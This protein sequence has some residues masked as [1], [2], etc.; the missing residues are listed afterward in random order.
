MTVIHRNLKTAG[1]LR[2]MIAE[3]NRKDLELKRITKTASLL[4]LSGLSANSIPREIAR[5]CAAEQRQ[6]GGWVGVVDSGWNAFFLK[7]LDSE[8]YGESIGKALDFIRSQVNEQGL[9]GRS[10]R[11]ISRIPVS[12]ILMYLFPGLAEPQPLL[13]LEQL[14]ISEKNSITYKAAYT[15]MAFKRARYRPQ[16]GTLIEETVDW[17]AA[18]QLQDGGFSPWKGHPLDADVFCTA[19]AALGLRQYP[20]LAAPE[21]LRRAAGWLDRN[22]LENGIWKYH[23]IEDGASWGLYALSQLLKDGVVEDG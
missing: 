5:R 15:L 4:L 16:T 20:N 11:D 9:W 12:G 14:W 3:M 18:N 8:A 6:D 10:P 21:V 7:S 13:L 22:R 1:A 23:E 17:L 19:V 2:N